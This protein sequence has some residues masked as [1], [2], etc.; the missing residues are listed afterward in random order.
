[1]DKNQLKQY[2][3]D[4]QL[5]ADFEALL[6]RTIDEAEQVDDALI[7]KLAELLD[8]QA[9]I[10]EDEADYLQQM[11]D[12]EENYDNDMER[13]DGEE[14]ADKAEAILNSQQTLVNNFKQKL[15]EVTGQQAETNQ[16]DQLRNQLSQ[17]PPQ[18]VP[19]ETPQ[20]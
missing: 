14:E 15:T 2:I 16:I 6:F 11:S 4:M 9:D 10:Y 12:L 8:A 5:E 13:I 7:E 17:Q 19:T 20:Q 1:M 18:P 3:M